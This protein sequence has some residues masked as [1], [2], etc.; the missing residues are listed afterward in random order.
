MPI[1]RQMA[2]PLAIIVAPTRELV[3]EIHATILNLCWTEK[4]RCVAVYGG[5]PVEEQL[6]KLSEGCDVLIATP[7][8]LLDFL[9]KS[10]RVFGR[11]QFLS[12]GRLQFMVYDEADALLSSGVGKERSFKE[13]ISAIEQMLPKD[14]DEDLYINHWFFSSHYTPEELKRADHLIHSFGKE[15]YFF[16]DFDMPDE[17]DSQRYVHVQ[18]SFIECDASLDLTKQRLEHMRDTFFPRRGLNAGKC[19]ILTHN[20]DAVNHI[21]FYVN[22]ELHL[23]CEK[24]HG[25]MTQAHREQAMH[26]FEQGHVSIL[27]ATMKLCG[28]VVNTDGIRDLVFWELPDTLD[29]Y[30]YCLKRVGRFGNDAKSTAFITKAGGDMDRG[31]IMG[32]KMKAFLEE[33]GQ[34]VPQGIDGDLLC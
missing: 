29:Q 12:L 17:E 11:K 14:R 23:R 30:K 8:R 7:G 1:R 6:H 22:T 13:E 16:I 2:E 15:G 31:A 28:R 9:Q 20:I 25:M 24:L 27:V 3:V 19:L 33:N 26:S 21:E 5:A 4:I 34:T 18:Q 10:T 32:P